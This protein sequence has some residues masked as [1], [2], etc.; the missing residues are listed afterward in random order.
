MNMG[1]KRQKNY[2]YTNK[3]YKLLHKPLTNKIKSTKEDKA[4]FFYSRKA[5]VDS[6]VSPYSKQ[7]HSLSRWDLTIFTWN[8]EFCFPDNA[9]LSLSL[10]FLKVR[11]TLCGHTPSLWCVQVEPMLLELSHWG[12][13]KVKI[14]CLW[15]QNTVFMGEGFM[16][17][18][19]QTNEFFYS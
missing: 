18:H 6:H 13:F 12:A 14:T 11:F 10:R 1:L 9:S 19:V 2:K 17:Q 15:G 16:L 7:I 3:V 5:N 8:A 4:S